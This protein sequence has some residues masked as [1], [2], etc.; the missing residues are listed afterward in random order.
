MCG[1]AGI[2]EIGA[3]KNQRQAN[4][5]KTMKQM[6]DVIQHR[7]PDGYGISSYGFANDF[8]D[9]QISYQ[10]API[11]NAKLLLGHRRLS[12]I[13]LSEQGRQPMLSNDKALEIIFN[14]EIYNYKELKE[15]L[16]SKYS[17]K[18]QSDTEVLLAAY[19]EWGSQM[20]TRLDGMFALV[21]LDK[22]R[23]KLICARDTSGIKPFYYYYTPGQFIFGSEPKVVRCGLTNAG[24]F[25]PTILSEFLLFGISDHDEGT[26]FQDITQL[27]AGHFLEYDLKN[28][29]LKKHQ[30]YHLPK[31]NLTKTFDDCQTLN[32]FKALFQEAVKRQLRADV[33]VGSSLSGGIDSGAIVTTIGDLLSGNSSNYTALTFSFPGFPNDESIF[34][35]S[36][37]AKS[38]LKWEPVMPALDSLEEDL[39]RMLVNMGEPFNTLSMFAQYKVMEQAHQ[40]GLKVMLDGQGGDEVYLGYPRVANRIGSAYFDQG[41]YLK[42]VQE[43]KAIKNNLSQSYTS[44]MLGKIYFNS[45]KI[46]SMKKRKELSAFMDWDYLSAYRPEVAGDLF[47]NKSI[48]EKQRDEFSKYI[49]PRLLKYADRNS[50]AFGVES[51]VPHLSPLILDYAFAL[52]VEW[53]VRNGWTKYIVRK[54]FSDKMPKEVIWNKKKLGFDIP[55]A[56]WV[57]QLRSLLK[58]WVESLS[59]DTPFNKEKII[60]TLE[61]DPGNKN[62]W[63]ILS[64]I[65]LI[66]HQ[67]ITI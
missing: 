58:I 42:G 46:A 53:K 21:I 24:Q 20:L 23:Q 59:T 45:Q 11:G 36:I 7:G 50:M 65:G 38:G 14:G 49:L 12:I 41:K 27:R 43:I 16:K 67:Q 62:L 54:S 33:K 15:E 13:D 60:K 52:P 34:A 37:A 28:D 40:L 29:T 35:K 39:S 26:F 61:S 10:Q 1:I 17:F 47:S 64:A 4:G 31:A 19:L 56:Y 22:N 63:P 55:Q 66:H 57:K 8:E 6:L 5:P 25:N 51:R 9:K 18:T 30:Y 48:Y 44:L 2:V 32:E 3:P